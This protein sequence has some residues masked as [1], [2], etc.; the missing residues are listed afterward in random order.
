MLGVEVGDG[1]PEVGTPGVDHLAVE[2]DAVALESVHA[3]G[4]GANID[5]LRVCVIDVEL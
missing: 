2:R 3:L 5:G 4:V 1:T